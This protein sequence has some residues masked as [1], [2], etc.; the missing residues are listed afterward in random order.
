MNEIYVIEGSAEDWQGAIKLCANKL[1]EN[2][3]VTESFYQHCVEREKE[4]PTGLSDECLVAIPHTEFEYVKKDALCILRLVDS[5]NFKRMDNPEEE[6]KVKYVINMAFTNGNNHLDAI[7]KVIGIASN[8]EY[9]S[10]LSEMSLADM[11][12]SLKE[13]LR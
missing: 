2:K 8:Q 5:V 4:Y 11:E 6:T 9:F 1:L 10:K 12:K 3:C 7:K 13:Y